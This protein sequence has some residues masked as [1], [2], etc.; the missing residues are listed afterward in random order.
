MDVDAVD[1][2]DP[3]SLFT[4]QKSRS[5]SES[6]GSP[7]LEDTSGHNEDGAMEAFDAT[8][9]RETRNI[10]AFSHISPPPLSPESRE[11]YLGLDLEVSSDDD[12]VDI[13]EIVGEYLSGNTRYLYARYDDG[14][15]RRVS[16]IYHICASFAL[17]V[18]VERRL[19]IQAEPFQF[20]RT[21]Q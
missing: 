16:F 4:P 8:P 11:K 13:L 6:P 19:E 9:N 15:V 3:L 7:I 1:A 10:D 5:A 2:G 20:V 18:D 14:I 17:I 21:V 12:D